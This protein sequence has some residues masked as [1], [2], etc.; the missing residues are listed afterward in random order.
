MQ[1]L[2]ENQIL[3]KYQNLY[4]FPYKKY[5]IMFNYFYVL[6]LLDCGKILIFSIIFSLLSL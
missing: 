4:H 3:N 2:W 6:L 1:N 5:D